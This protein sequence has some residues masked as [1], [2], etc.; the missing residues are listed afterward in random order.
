MWSYG[1]ETHQY[2][3][4]NATSMTNEDLKNYMLYLNKE[5]EKTMQKLHVLKRE[6]QELKLKRAWEK[7]AKEIKEREARE[8]I[9]IKEREE[10]KR[11]E[12]I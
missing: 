6:R 7:E 9:E 12:I 8:R 2:P 11:I 5:K 4:W 1:H 3:N 10:R